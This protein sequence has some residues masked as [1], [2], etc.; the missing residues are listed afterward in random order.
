MNPNG[1]YV[2]PVLNA[3]LQHGHIH[4]LHMARSE[5]GVYQQEI[6]SNILLYFFQNE[7]T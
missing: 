5:D 7:I 2:K 1:L 3:G 4:A 6:P